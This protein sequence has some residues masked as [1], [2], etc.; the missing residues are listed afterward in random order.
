MSDIPKY[1]SDE[2][3]KIRARGKLLMDL[4]EVIIEQYGEKEAI[5][6]L[7][8]YKKSKEKGDTK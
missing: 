7:A 4:G 8:D 3:K 2:Y 1:G 6:L 5:K